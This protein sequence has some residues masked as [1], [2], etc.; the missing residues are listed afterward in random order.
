MSVQLFLIVLS[1]EIYPNQEFFILSLPQITEQQYCP[2]IDL[3][4]SMNFVIR[5]FK[6]HE[7]D[8]VRQ[9]GNNE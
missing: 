7:Y 6:P 3:L 5:P 2:I 8:M 9:W 1:I 4:N